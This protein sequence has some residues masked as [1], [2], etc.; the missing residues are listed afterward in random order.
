MNII[1]ELENTLEGFNSKL[2]E[3]I[4]NLEDKMVESIR[5]E[6]QVKNNFKK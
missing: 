1:T 3:W 2:E 5:T 6:K 4:S